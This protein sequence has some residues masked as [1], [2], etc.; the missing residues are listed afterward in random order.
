MGLLRPV[1]SARNPFGSIEMMS[2]SESATRNGRRS[3]IG[4]SHVKKIENLTVKESEI[5]NEEIESEGKTMNEEAEV[6]D[7]TIGTTSTIV[8]ADSPLENMADLI[9]NGTRTL[10]V[11]RIATAISLQNITEMTMK[12]RGKT[13]KIVDCLVVVVITRKAGMTHLK[14]KRV[15]ETEVMR[16]AG[17][18][19]SRRTGL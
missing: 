19:E 14:R 10:T 2:E 12:K 15:G 11:K 16:M 3:A 17:R 13:R 4:T 7:T 18:K 5:R 6:L 1:G 9:V 8:N